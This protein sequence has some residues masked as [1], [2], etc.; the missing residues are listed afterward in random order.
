MKTFIRLSIFLTALTLYGCIDFSLKLT[1]NKDGSGTL[2]ESILMNKEIIDMISGMAMA[3][4]EDTAAS[5]KFSLY[6]VEKIKQEAA[7]RGSGVEYVSSEQIILPDKE[8]YNVV[9]KFSD[10]NQLSI[11]QNPMELTS[12][13]TL[14]GQMPMEQSLGENLQFNFIPG[15]TAELEIIFPEQGIEDEELSEEE[16]TMETDEASFEEMKAFM[17]GFRISLGVE[18]NGNIVETN[19]SYVE[20][21]KVTLF[22]IDFDKLLDNEEKFNELKNLRPGD[23]STIKDVMKNIPGFQIETNTPV[24]IKFK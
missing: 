18:V 7:D 12:M 13:N 4:G 17:R 5:E 24:K 20:S 14:S 22:D 16:D 23:F 15:S 2:E 19:A 3:F 11:K 6:D 8:G 1:V 21:S 10:V 9:Y